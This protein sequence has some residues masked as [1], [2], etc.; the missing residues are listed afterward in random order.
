VFIKLGAWVGLS[1]LA[2][3]G[4]RRRGAARVLAIVALVLAFVAILSVYLKPTL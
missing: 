1:A 3:L 2:G 4:Y